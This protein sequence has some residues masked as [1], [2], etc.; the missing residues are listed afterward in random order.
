[1]ENLFKAVMRSNLSTDTKFKIFTILDEDERYIASAET[2]T[3]TDAHIVAVKAKS[4]NNI[5][6]KHAD[7]VRLF[8]EIVKLWGPVNAW[9]G[10]VTPGVEDYAGSLDRLALEFGRTRG[11]IKSQ[12][13]DAVSSKVTTKNATSIKKIKDAAVDAGLIN[14]NDAIV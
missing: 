3:I 4:M 8:K 9:G 11:S 12:I 1:M 10:A 14:F 2:P 7:R 13:N 6:W 5:S